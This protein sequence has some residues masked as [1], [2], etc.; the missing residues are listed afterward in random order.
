MYQ[1]ISATMKMQN[2]IN[3][4]VDVHAEDKHDLI[5]ININ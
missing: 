4:S 2:K 5:S 1:S 3:K